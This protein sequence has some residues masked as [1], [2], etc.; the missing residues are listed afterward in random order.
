MFRFLIVLTSCVF[1]LHSAAAQHDSLRGRYVE[2]FPDKFFIWPVLKQ[3]E[4]S[5]DIQNRYDGSQKLSYK[6]NN[7][8]SI[9]LGVY[10]FEVAFEFSAAIPLDERSRNTY[11]AS[12]I[13]DLQANFLGKFW[14]VDLY[15]QNYS[16]F[17][18]ANQNQGPTSPDP[19]IKRSDIK[20]LNTGTNFIYAFNRSKYSLK[21]AFNYSEKQ[22][23]SA[24]SFIIAGSVNTA[25]LQADSSVVD[26]IYSPDQ[27]SVS[28]FRKLQYAAFGLAPGYAHSLIY[29]SF[30]LNGAFSVGPAH[31]WINYSAQ[32]EVDYDMSIN[33]YM[34][35]R[36]ALGYNSNRIFGGVSYIIQSRNIR[37]ENIEFTKN[38]STLKFLVG[39]RFH[40]KGV[41]KKRAKDYV[42]GNKSAR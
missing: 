18:V 6:P 1:S 41:L 32:D 3:R 22:L 13:R 16:G 5:F 39:Y 26:Q 24:G 11:G 15:R 7:S 36:L 2:E 21:A 9:G 19:F 42:P 29:R 33:T 25:R 10:L 30:F 40:E 12:D 31:Y 27:Y 17:Y 20:V 34:D 28:S 23:K 8:Y 14:G 38:S 4:L 35:I 37:F